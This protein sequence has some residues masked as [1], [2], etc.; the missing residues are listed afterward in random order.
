LI[1]EF[2]GIPGSGKSYISNQLYQYLKN[3]L[4]G[5]R[6]F[7]HQDICNEVKKD[8]KILIFLK[9]LRLMLS[10]DFNRMIFSIL[11]R[12]SSIY[13]RN[14]MLKRFLKRTIIYQKFKDMKCDMDKSILILDEG[15]THFSIAYFRQNNEIPDRKNINIYLNRLNNIIGYSEIPKLFVF[16][17]TNVEKSYVRIE[18]REQG[19]PGSIGRLDKEKRVEY[20]KQTNKCYFQLI[21][22]LKS[23]DKKIIIENNNYQE[24]Y[25]NYFRDMIDYVKTL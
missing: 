1:I 9:V 16:V 10:K 15:F 6:V 18:R 13:E 17:H 7:S 24:S 4:K 12:K 2:I 21:D 11:R 8:G 23:N 25:S 20:L 14:N 5:Y 22:N 3:E 19:W